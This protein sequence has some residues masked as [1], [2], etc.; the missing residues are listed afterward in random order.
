MSLRPT[1]ART[2]A[3][4]LL[5]GG[6]GLRAIVIEGLPAPGEWTAVSMAWGAPEKRDAVLVVDAEAGTDA[7]VLRGLSDGDIVT[8]LQVLPVPPVAQRVILTGSG[9]FTRGEA[10]AGNVIYAGRAEARQV[11]ESLAPV[12]EALAEAA[13]VEPGVVTLEH[14]QTEDVATGESI[15]LGGFDIDP[16]S[17]PNGRAVLSASGDD[18]RALVLGNVDSAPGVSPSEKVRL[19]LTGAGE[20]TISGVIEAGIDTLTL[21]PAAGNPTT[22]TGRGQVRLFGP[23]FHGETVIGDG[24]NAVGEIIVN[25]NRSLGVGRITLADNSDATLSALGLTPVTLANDINFGDVD[26]GKSLTF[27]SSGNTG[28]ITVEGNININAVTIPNPLIITSINAFAGTTVNL[29][30]IISAP[31]GLTF[32]GSGGTFNLDAD[33]DLLDA[34]GRNLIAGN[35]SVT[36]NETRV[37]LPTP[38][39]YMEGTDFNLTRGGQIGLT[40][41]GLEY[42]V[43]LLGGGSA[44]GAITGV[45]AGSVLDLG[46]GNTLLVLDADTR[47]DSAYLGSVVGTDGAGITFDIDPGAATEVTF[48]N[49]SAGIANDS[50][51]DG[52]LV[53][54]RAGGYE[55]S[56]NARS[57]PT[58]GAVI[59]DTLPGQEPVRFRFDENDGISNTFNGA[60][61]GPDGSLANAEVIIN[62]SELNGTGT[63][64][65]ELFG[66]NNVLR[67]IVNAG[68]LSGRVNSLQAPVRLEENGDLLVDI[69]AGTPVVWA[70]ILDVSETSTVF[71]ESSGAGESIITFNRDWT[72]TERVGVPGGFRGALDLTSTT[73][74][75]E[76]AGGGVLAAQ[77][78]TKVVVDSFSRLEGSVDFH[79]AEVFSSGIIAPDGGGS[80]VAR[81]GSISTKAVELLGQSA[82]LELAA[83][84]IGAGEFDL[85]S[86]RSRVIL[87]GSLN[88]ELV[89]NPASGDVFLP[90]RTADTGE[91]VPVVSISPPEDEAVGSNVSGL[92]DSV[93][94]VIEGFTDEQ[95]EAFRGTM[96]LVY[97]SELSNAGIEL[98]NGHEGVVLAVTQESLVGLTELT[99]PQEDL[100]LALDA[101]ISLGRDEDLLRLDDTFLRALSLMPA[102]ELPARLDEIR[103]DLLPVSTR[104]FIERASFAQQDNLA[105]QLSI[106]MEQLRANLPGQKKDDYGFF[107]QNDASRVRYEDGLGDATLISGGFTAG[108]EWMPREAMHAGGFVAYQSG[109]TDLGGPEAGDLQLNSFRLGMFATWFGPK[110]YL[111]AVLSAGTLSYEVDRVNGFG[112]QRM[113][114]EG[115]QQLALLG[116]GWE[117]PVGSQFSLNPYAAIQAARLEVSAAGETG[118]RSL[119]FDGYVSHSLKTRIGLDFAR[120]FAT[121]GSMQGRALFRVAWDHEFSNEAEQ[122]VAAF[123]DA[124]DSSFAFTSPGIDADTVHFALQVQAYFPEYLS[125]YGGYTAELRD[126]LFGLNV[127]AGGRLTF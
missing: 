12:S 112:T 95:S 105:R 73:A 76:R 23:N 28:A 3:A 127:S 47:R 52:D 22:N 43:G 9:A 96:L 31:E 2:V 62:A 13:T 106:Y 24:I 38:Q 124:P 102:G 41:A 86:A 53:L 67:Y 121:R 50:N 98:L 44:S 84:G 69:I 49:E 83:G 48:R 114:P 93:G 120:D 94:L 100:A 26:S 66:D 14:G 125:V 101:L 118:E 5:V 107:F 72:D 111:E 58:G 123:A 79:R 32:G 113:G 103:G 10:T 39:A 104:S 36:G 15:Y 78:A 34:L 81:F 110:W 70:Q 109:E 115:K 64:T 117:L 108:V 18:A 122:L 54:K 11:L 51:Y 82:G 20:V 85:V 21:T 25:D 46:S 65:V 91:Y 116:F 63:F 119:V 55:F 29:N 89:G 45:T 19:E 59:I 27:G 77:D 60:I 7:P 30:G 6:V 97:P 88:V 71:T 40:G 68:E 92:F 80:G 75:F 16:G 37:N 99:A 35:L 126:G 33:Q 57:L 90:G 17:D 8:H 74:R 61:S 87:D 42:D 1:C 4:A 56:T